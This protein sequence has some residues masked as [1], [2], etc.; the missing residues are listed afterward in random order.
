MGNDSDNI[1]TFLSDYFDDIDENTE[2]ETI[3][4]KI[5]GEKNILDNSINKIS[6]INNEIKSDLDSLME[7][8]KEMEKTLIPESS[9]T[10]ETIIEEENIN[11]KNINLLKN[12]FNKY[13]DNSRIKLSKMVNLKNRFLELIRENQILIK[14]KKFISSLSDSCLSKL[15][16]LNK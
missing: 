6:D 2:I 10:I 11:K 16:E 15:K 4:K 7:N 14:E 3:I 9:Q 8:I 5:K 1:I 13:V 12:E